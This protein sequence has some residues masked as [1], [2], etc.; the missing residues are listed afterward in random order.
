[1]SVLLVRH[2]WAGK[3]KEWDGDDLLRP[4]D[5]RGRRQARALVDLLSEFDVDRIVSSPARRCRQTV[6][7]LAV[8]RGLKV[9]ERVEL[10]EEH[11]EE[12]G[13]ELLEQLAGEPVVLATHGGRPWSALAEPH[14][15]EKGATVV[16]GAG[17]TAVRYVPAP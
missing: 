16:L 15:Y 9:E 14:R 11:Q 10:S 2:A 12:D 5:E 1:M 17:L 13:R 8:A 6:E 7:P 3:R 4:L